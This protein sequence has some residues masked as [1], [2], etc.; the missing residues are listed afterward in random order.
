M[1]LAEIVRHLPRLWVLRR[2]LLSEL[3]EFRPDVF[4]GVDAPELNLG[5]AG[6]MKRAG[7]A[8]RAIRMPLHMGL[9]RGVGRGASGAAATRSCACCRLNP[10]CCAKRALQPSL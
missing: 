8:H 7:R 10:A 5:L 3:A 1:G 4:V 9:A 2:R 6:R